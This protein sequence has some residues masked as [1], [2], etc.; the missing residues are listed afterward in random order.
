MWAANEVRPDAAV[1]RKAFRQVPGAAGCGAMPRHGSGLRV[2]PWALSLFMMMGFL[3][4]Q[5]H[6]TP[7]PVLRLACDAKADAALCDAM[8][9]QLDATANGQ[10]E[11]RR[12][13]YGEEAPKAAKDLGLALHV[14]QQGQGWVA[15][16]ISWQFGR[17]NHAGRGPSVELSVMDAPLSSAMY[18]R[19]A[20]DLIRADPAM[21][22][23]ISPDRPCPN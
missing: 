6:A 13:P 4:P 11:V 15:A 16:H 1:R 7:L 21:E 18:S 8:Q 22:S 2:A 19:L 9:H 20:A 5:A 3:M 10:F 14:D 12:V 17:D 23:L